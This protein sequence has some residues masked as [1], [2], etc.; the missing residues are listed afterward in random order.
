MNLTSA[1]L[2]VLACNAAFK[3]PIAKAEIDL[4]LASDK[5]GMVVT[6]RDLRLVEELAGGRPVA[7]CDH[8]GL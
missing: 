3:Q 7:L 1:T 6:I 5:R 2:E 4:F 8:R